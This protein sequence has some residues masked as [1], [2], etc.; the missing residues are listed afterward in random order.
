VQRS[1]WFLDSAAGPG[2]ERRDWYIWADEDPGYLGPWGQEVWHPKN[3]ACAAPLTVG[4][5]GVVA[6]YQPLPDL[7]PRSALILAPATE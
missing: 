4:P 3:G 7:P 6:G 5:G 1:L 2:S